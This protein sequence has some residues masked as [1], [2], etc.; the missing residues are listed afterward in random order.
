MAMVLGLAASLGVSLTTSAAGQINV[1]AAGSLR[2]PLT[3]AAQAYEQASGVKVVLVFGASGLLKER[4]EKGESADVFASA[5]TEHPQALADSGRMATPVTFTRNQMC[6]LAAPAIAVTSETLLDRMLQNS[7]KLGTSTPKA[8]PSGDYAWKVFEK[9]ERVS[10][11]AFA[12]LSAKALKLTGGP[13]SP[14]PPKDRSG[15]GELVATGKADIFLL[16]CTSAVQAVK[17]QTQLRQIALPRSLAV[18]ADYGVAIA[19]NANPGAQG[20]VDYLVS[21]AGQKSFARFGFA[22]V[23]GSRLTIQLPSGQTREISH[24]DIQKL[25]PFKVSAKAHCKSHEWQGTKLLTLLESADIKF[26][27]PSGGGASVRQYL[28]LEGDDGYKVVFAMGELDP[29]MTTSPPMVAWLQDGKPLSADEAPLR[30]IVA[31]EPRG[32][33]QVRKISRITVGQID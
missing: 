4:I 12:S 20:F 17:D 11:G 30:L 8:D 6:A 13:D 3:E 19:K 23:A 21:D 27:K 22:R 15:Y 29:I 28:I 9:A 5:N 14:P 32:A 31:G 16:Y 1:Y 25:E 7:V 2:G 18:W 26:E 33:R 24:A 10:P